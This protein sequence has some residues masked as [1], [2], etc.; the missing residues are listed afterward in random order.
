[1]RFNQI[2]T[3]FVTHHYKN[4]KKPFKRNVPTFYWPLVLKGK[5]QPHQGHKEKERR[6]DR[7]KQR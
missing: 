3:G 5:Y 2:G 4:R 6:R 7:S 1:M